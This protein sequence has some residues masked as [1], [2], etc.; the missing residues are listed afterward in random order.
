[1]TNLRI[2]G[3]GLAGV[4]GVAA[5]M[6]A[7]PATAAPAV[8]TWHTTELRVPVHAA[9]S[10]QSHLFSAAC[11]ST[12]YCVLGG[13]YRAASGADEAM[14]VA[15]SK[16]RWGRAG[17]L[18]MPSGAAAD[19]DAD[20]DSLACTGS[21]SCVAVG[22]YDYGAGKDEQAFIATESR[23]RWARAA[24]IR[25]PAGRA[26]AT[27]S[28]LGAVSCP[29]PGSCVAAGGYA[30]KGGGY[31]LMVITQSKGKWGRAQSLE[32]PQND[33]K[34]PVAGISGLACPKAGYCSA[35]GSLEVG[36]ALN[37]RPLAVTE[38]KGRWG[39]PA[40]IG[41]PKGAVTASQDAA[42]SS[43]ACSG[44][45][46]CEAVGSYVSSGGLGLIMAAAESRGRWHAASQLRLPADTGTLGGDSAELFGVACTGAGACTAVGGYTSTAESAGGTP[47]AMAVTESRGR[48]NRAVP[49]GAP[50]N[51]GG[52]AGAVSF[53]Y[54]VAC[55][56]SSS[57]VAGGIYADKSG[58][59]Q[60]MA[61]TGP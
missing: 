61:A 3:M 22:S 36:T 38:S 4:A 21:G 15:Q 48:W 11:A 40:E 30:V 24:S 27:D 23:G 28:G 59:R 2:G 46:S 32:Q 49:V 6:I 37:F 29:R 34:N 17:E 10:P 43:V 58:K 41:L 39:R 52:G 12:A 16:G 44:T 51:A 60:P 18:A 20:V 25:L 14:L 42:L 13:Y 26:A 50:A 1:M 54:A 55:P 33:G 53:L 56:K 31:R 35:V 8:T 45:G 7:M 47:Q 5:V 19:P 9:V 57:C